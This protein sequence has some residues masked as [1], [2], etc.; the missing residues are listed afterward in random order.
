MA[1][2]LGKKLSKGERINLTKN[3]DDSNSEKVINI[4]CGINWSGIVHKGWFGNKSVE[5]VDLDSTVLLYDENKR[6]IGEVSFRNLNLPGIHHSGDDREG[7]AN[8]DDGLDNEV[9]SVDLT[10]VNSK[11]M[12]LVFILN[13]YSHQKF[14]KI[15]YARI[16]IY[17]GTPKRVNNVLA[18]YELSS[19]PD[20]VGKEAIV[21]GHM[22]KR[23]DWWKFKADGVC[24]SERS[25]NEIAQGSALSVL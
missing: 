18:S 17:E 1:L 7:D 13:S 12:Y 21:L 4:C 5:A 15:P 11:A 8:G 2:E 16:R 14:D 3:V 22:Y 25:I 24:T 20:F 23:N 9:I 10:K 6:Y 19:D